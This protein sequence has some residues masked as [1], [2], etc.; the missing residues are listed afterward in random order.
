MPFPLRSHRVLQRLEGRVARGLSGLSFTRLNACSVKC[1]PGSLQ[2]EYRASGR[3]RL[4][5]PW[6]ATNVRKAAQMAHCE[7]MDR[8]QRVRFMRVCV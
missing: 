5:D 2:G 8:R 6:H 4:P 1:T 7:A 3:A